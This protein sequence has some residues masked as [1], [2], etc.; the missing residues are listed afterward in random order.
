[1]MKL[2]T[3]YKLNRTI[4]GGVITILLFD[5]YDLEHVLSVALGS[6]IIF[7]TFDLRQLIRAWIIAFLMLVRY[8]LWPLTC[9]PWKFVLNQVSRWLKSGQN[10]SKIEQSSA[11]LFCDFCTRYVSPFQL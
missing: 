7:T 8:V 5:F 1:M 6:G 11:E 4:R 9:W 3:K 10:L 2:R